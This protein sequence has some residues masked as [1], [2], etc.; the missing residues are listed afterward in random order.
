[1]IYRVV[2]KIPSMYA[3]KFVSYSL[4]TKRLQMLKLHTENKKEVGSKGN[5][6]VLSEVFYLKNPLVR[7]AAKNITISEIKRSFFCS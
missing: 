4:F 5:R 3:R 1:M 6:T 2:I 7:A